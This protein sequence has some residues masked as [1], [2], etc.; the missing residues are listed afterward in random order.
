VPQWGTYDVI[1]RGSKI[2]EKKLNSKIMLKFPINSGRKPF[3]GS[4]I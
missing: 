2:F 3:F 1:K 4:R